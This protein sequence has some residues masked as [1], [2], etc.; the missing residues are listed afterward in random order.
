MSES[1]SYFFSA[2]AWSTR[3]K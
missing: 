2:R 3:G 1:A